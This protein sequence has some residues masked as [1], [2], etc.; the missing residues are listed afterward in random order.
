LKGIIAG[1]PVATNFWP[2]DL[3]P[4]DFPKCR[5]LTY[6]YDSLVSRGLKGAA[7][8]ATILDH[9]RE[10]LD[11]LEEERRQAL[12]R[13][14]IFIAHSLGGLLLKA[15]LRQASE[16]DATTP[17]GRVI[18]DVSE[19]TIG[20]IFLGTP[21]RG[22]D[23]AQLGELIANV[24]RAVQFDRSNNVLKDLNINSTILEILNDSFK[25]MC[26]TQKFTLVTFEEGR[27][28]GIPIVARDKVVQSWSAHLDYAGEQK[29][30]INAD[31][32]RMCRFSGSD[33]PGYRQLK[34]AI[35]KCI[36]RA[37]GN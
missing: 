27:G 8:Q 11:G 17:D 36:R 33:S 4:Q 12:G 31:H 18:H 29:G 35:D 30:V 14:L 15:V 20:T 24:A 1:K 16:T 10:L 6:G 26:S 32:R 5:V 9:A 23:Y 19:S 21:H 22:S 3:L 37:S 34:R 13:P 25:K 2:E 28:L 7:N